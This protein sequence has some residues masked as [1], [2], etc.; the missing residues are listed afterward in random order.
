MVLAVY[1]PPFS[2][3]VDTYGRQRILFSSHSKSTYALKSLFNIQM[4]QTP[5]EYWKQTN[6][7]QGHT[8][9]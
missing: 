6:F 4:G 2:G 7:F 1:P 5:A 8:G 9:V 3:S